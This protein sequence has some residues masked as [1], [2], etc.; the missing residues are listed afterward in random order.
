MRGCDVHVEP[1][2]PAGQGS[3]AECLKKLGRENEAVKL[4]QETLCAWPENN[5]ARKVFRFLG[6]VAS[7]GKTMILGFLQRGSKQP[8]APK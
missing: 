3:Q 8:Q 4:E 1:S 5:M 2:T 6:M 7:D